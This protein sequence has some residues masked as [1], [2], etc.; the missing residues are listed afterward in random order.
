[1]NNQ[2]SSYSFKTVAYTILKMRE[3][4]Q[5][6]KL[7]DTQTNFKYP[8]IQPDFQTAQKNSAHLRETGLS[9]E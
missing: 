1:M 6:S 8:E 2:K 5:S 4:S 9:R 7:V 3:S